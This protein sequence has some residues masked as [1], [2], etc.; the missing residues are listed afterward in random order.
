MKDIVFDYGRLRQRMKDVCGSQ[1]N[2]SKEIGR[3]NSYITN[4]L[5]GKSEI[6]SSDIVKWARYLK[7]ADEDIADFFFCPKDLQM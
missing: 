6:T 2:F 7:I 4:V 1:L 3:S 5:M